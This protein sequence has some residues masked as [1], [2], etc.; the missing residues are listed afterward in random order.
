MLILTIVRKLQKKKQE[1][2][3][4]RKGEREREREEREWWGKVG[5]LGRGDSLIFVGKYVARRFF[6]DLFCFDGCFCNLR[7][8]E[9]V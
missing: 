5:D 1:R 8:K 7:E 9:M 6:L 4:E 2:E 3:R